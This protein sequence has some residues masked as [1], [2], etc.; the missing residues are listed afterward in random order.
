MKIIRVRMSSRHPVY[1][2]IHHKTASPEQLRSQVV[3]TVVGGELIYDL[4]NEPGEKVSRRSARYLAAVIPSL[5][6]RPRG[7]L[8]EKCVFFFR[9]PQHIVV[10][11]K[12]SEKKCSAV[13]VFFT[14]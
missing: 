2:C 11:S 8:T 7:V 6:G 5:D 9:K 3:H 12:S 1:F 10:G 13:A 14:T 4:H